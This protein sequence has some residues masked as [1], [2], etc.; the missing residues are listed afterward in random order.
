MADSPTQRSLRLLR[1]AYRHVAIVEK[2]NPHAKIRQDLFGFA[3][4]IAFGDESVALIQTTS[5]SN[6]S[7]RKKKILENE[8]AKEWMEGAMFRD[9]TLHGWKKNKSNRWELRSYNF[10]REDFA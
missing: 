8:A 10:S 9:I 1:K 7:A 4:L 2:W 6:M 3:D 5:Y